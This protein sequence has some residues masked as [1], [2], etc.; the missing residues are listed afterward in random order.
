MLHVTSYEK[1]LHVG[2]GLVNALFLAEEVAQL[3][4]LLPCETFDGGQAT[5]SLPLLVCVEPLRL[6]KSLNCF[7]AAIVIA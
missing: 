2:D 3:Q 5:P 1:C 6:I 7:F 4:N